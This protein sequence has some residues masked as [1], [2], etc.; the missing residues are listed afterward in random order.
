[1]SAVIAQ[2]GASGLP[3]VDATP[4]PAPPASISG[5]SDDLAPV[6]VDASTEEAQPTED[7][8]PCDLPDPPDW[9]NPPD[10]WHPEVSVTGWDDWGEWNNDGI[11]GGQGIAPT[12]TLPD[13]VEQTPIVIT[14]MT[15]T[16]IEIR[17]SVLPYSQTVHGDASVPAAGPTINKPAGEQG[18]PT[19]TIIAQNRP[20]S[21]SPD[22]TSDQQKVP[23]QPA[24]HSPTALHSSAPE[25]VASGQQSGK[26][27]PNTALQ[28]T[29]SSGNDLL[30]AIIERLGAPESDAQSPAPTLSVVEAS[31]EHTNHEP[32]LAVPT[33]PAVVGQGDQAQTGATIPGPITQEP[34]S[35]A[36]AYDIGTKSNYITLG[37]VTLTLTP[38]LSTS[39]G[40][41]TSATLIAI[42]TD[43]AS[44]TIIVISSSGTAITATMTVAPATVT[45]SKNN[46][47]SSITGDA[48]RG[49]PTSLLRV[50]AATT[51]SGAAADKR[52][53]RNSGFSK[54]VF[55]I[56]G[57]VL[58]L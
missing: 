43:S 6:P 3:S 30:D 56:L 32:Q 46:F 4:T 58:V 55:G 42:Q 52:E 15:P 49:V 38:G 35:I 40:T 29:V 2:S 14:T 54:L 41:G 53:A 37:S 18:I 51:S 19:Q 21:S 25:S 27:D 24:L 16:V 11:G 5:G 31:G 17:T 34:V 28:Q 9:C 12:T 23:V 20:Q 13:P 33:G 7:I 8:Y 50:P 44:H 1:M 47:A 22:E 39:L 57:V 26:A 36:S 10:F 48:S 45:L